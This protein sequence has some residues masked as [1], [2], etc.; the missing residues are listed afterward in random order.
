MGPS[1]EGWVAWGWAS[2]GGSDGKES[3]RGAGDP[4]SKQGWGRSSEGG[5]VTLSCILAWRVPWTEDPVDRPWGCTESTV[6]RVT[7]SQT[8]L[9]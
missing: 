7:Q 6:H 5:H 3:A 1:F 9:K 2:W 8:G 4:G